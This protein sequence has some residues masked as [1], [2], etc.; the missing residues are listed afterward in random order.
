MNTEITDKTNTE[1]AGGE[2]SVIVWDDTC[3]VCN[4]FKRLVE[5]RAMRAGYTF[6]SMRVWREDHPDAS[7]EGMYVITPEGRLRFAADAA[8]H[9]AALN[10]WLRP[11]CGLARLPIL[12]SFAAA[13]YRW[14]AAHRHM[15]GCK[16]C[17]GGDSACS[18]HSAS[19]KRAD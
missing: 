8:L 13:G 11:F 19:Q 5:G 7:T 2:R 15:V 16:S 18:L 3:A 10:P 1:A 9:V 6:R 12:R 4:R 14:L 17:E